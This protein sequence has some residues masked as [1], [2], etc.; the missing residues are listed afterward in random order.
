MGFIVAGTLGGFL[1]P[2]A[3]RVGG[4]SPP[5]L[6]AVYGLH[7]CGNPGRFPGPPAVR[8]GGLSPPSLGAIC[9]SRALPYRGRRAEPADPR[10]VHRRVGGSCAPWGFG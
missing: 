8:G 9:G 4:L 7:C 1:G 10:R 5:T 2:P 6:S 3:M